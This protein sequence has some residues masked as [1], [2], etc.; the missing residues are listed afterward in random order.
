MCGEIKGDRERGGRTEGRGS[1]LPHTSV[2]NIDTI[3]L[4]MRWPKRVTAS[5][6][7]LQATNRR[8]R[9]D[10]LPDSLFSADALRRVKHAETKKQRDGTGTSRYI[11]AT[12]CLPS[13]PAEANKS[14]ATAVAAGRGATSCLS[15]AK[16]EKEA[17]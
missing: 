5:T 15:E 1:M 10:F 3:K 12:P 14:A 2:Q 13:T 17:R 16:T 11:N 8:E 7:T 9:G 6:Q 4:T